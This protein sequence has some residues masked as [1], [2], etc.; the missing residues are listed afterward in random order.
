VSLFGSVSAGA[1]SLGSALQL[2]DQ[3][4]QKQVS[5]KEPISGDTVYINAVDQEDYEMSVSIT[6]FPITDQGTALDYISR[7]NNPMSL[8]GFI[9]NRNLDLKTDPVNAIASHA[10]GFAPAIAGAVSAGLGLA[11]SLGLDLGKDEIDKK[12]E[13]L[14]KWMNAGLFVEV[15]G[16]KINAKKFSSEG[17]GF[18]YLI[19]NVHP[20]S[21]GD[22]GDGAGVQITFKHILPVVLTPVSSRGTSLTDKLLG[23][24]KQA[25]VNPFK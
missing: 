2:A 4:F 6:D 21:N 10:A 12:L 1:A 9:S 17:D 7:N 15:L 18:K 16:M 20:V 5:I 23:N 13:L 19:E 22:T 3:L 24:L 25:F 8:T 14:N 11:S